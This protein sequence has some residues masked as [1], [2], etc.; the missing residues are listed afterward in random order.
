MKYSEVQPPKIVSGQYGTPV[1]PELSCDLY[2]ITGLQVYTH[3]F[4]P[5]HWSFN[6][7]LLNIE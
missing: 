3:W 6:F 2:P 5:Y 1:L 4:I 7:S